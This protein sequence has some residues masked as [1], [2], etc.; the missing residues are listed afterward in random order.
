MGFDRSVV[1]AEELICRGHHVDPVRFSFGSLFI[2][3]QVH[4]LIGRSVLEDYT[5][6]K[7]QRSAQGRRS[8][9][10]HSAV[11]ICYLPGVIRRR[12]KASKGHQRLFG[13]KAANI[14]NLRH[15]LRAE[16]WSHTKHLHDDGILR[17]EGCQLQH[18]LF[19]R[20][21]SE[22]CG[23]KL[24]YGLLHQEFR[25]IGLWHN[26][27]VPTGGGVDIQRLILAEVVTVC[28][29]PFLVLGYESLFRQATDTFTVPESG[30][31]GLPRIRTTT[32]LPFRV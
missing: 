20:R 12:V 11:V 6:H 9:F 24:C 29:A 15:E 25:G 22:G 1:N 19:E 18:L 27:E 2:H 14:A 5:H 31:K 32:K 16:R 23:S 7:K 21:Q 26:C 8:T 10:G 28:L 4:R 3:E 13:V 17:Q 30:D